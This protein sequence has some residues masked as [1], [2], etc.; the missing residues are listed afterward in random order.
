MTPSHRLLALAG[1]DPEVARA[2]GP[3]SV[4]RLTWIALAHLLPC[5][6]MG[7]AGGYA[8]HLTQG[9]AWLSIAAG[10]AFAA[11]VLNLLRVSVAGG[12]MAPHKT[13]LQTERFRPAMPPVI[14]V[15]VLAGLLAQPAILPLFAAELEPD[16]AAHRA[17]LLRRHRAAPPPERVTAS[18]EAGQLRAQRAERYAHNVAAASFAARRV[19]MVWRQPARPAALT[20]AF[21]LACA[22]PLLLARVPLVSAVRHYERAR[23]ERLQVLLY[24][25]EATTAREVHASL[26]RFASYE[27]V[28]AIALRESWVPKPA[29]GVT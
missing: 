25:L 29:G 1:Y 2:L 11:F 8:A 28:H 24:A 20:L 7:W 27:G 19:T 3:S 21:V 22:L 17:E 26:A 14:V 4:R 18:S 23:R 9:S 5:G 13:E 15:A 16:V 6:L 10:V 12:G